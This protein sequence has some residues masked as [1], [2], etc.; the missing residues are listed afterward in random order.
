MRDRAMHFTHAHKHHARYPVKVVLF[1]V[2]LWLY[3]S[4]VVLNHLATSYM[5]C[6][7]NNNKMKIG[8]AIM[9]MYQHNRLIMLLDLCS[10]T[11]SLG[12]HL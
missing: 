8:L 2:S 3:F 1:V 9:S 6:A 4:F 7:M 10:L 12:L 11:P 5:I